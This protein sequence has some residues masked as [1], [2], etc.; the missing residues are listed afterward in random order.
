MD[1]QSYIVAEDYWS[2]FIEF[3]V[4]HTTSTSA[5]IGRLKRYFATHGVPKEVVTDNGSQFVSAEFRDFG[6][7]W[8]FKHTTVSPY[9]HRANGLAESAVKLVYN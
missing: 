9:H 1:N 2:N 3:D 8:L 6:K 5:V 4:L 7:K